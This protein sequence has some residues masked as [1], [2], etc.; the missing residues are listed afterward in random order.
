MPNAASLSAI[1]QGHLIQSIDTSRAANDRF[2]LPAFLRT[3][4]DSGLTQLETTDNATALT[5]SDRAGGS[6]AARAALTALDA[7]LHDGYK[8]IDAIRSTTITPAQRL[9]VFT[10][11]GWTGGKLGTFNDARVLGLAR[12]GVRADVG[13]N[14]VWAY[15]ADLIADLKAQLAIYQANAGP[16]TGGDRTGATKK[17]DDALAEVE[18]T[19]ARI[20][21][22]YCCASED[23][24]QTTELTRIGFQPRRDAS[25]TPA[26]APAPSPTPT[27]VPPTA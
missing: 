15:S 20:R 13:I 18:T 24:D 14:P 6:A 22:Y 16:A 11:Y 5:E 10:T 26:P 3:A 7:L 1:A 12:L 27:P 9:E 4:L 25:P 21:F 19:L 23:T 17:R 2:H 8:A